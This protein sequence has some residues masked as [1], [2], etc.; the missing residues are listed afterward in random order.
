LISG[1]SSRAHRGSFVIVRRWWKWSSKCPGSLMP[2]LAWRDEVCLPR[3]G[4]HS[5]FDSKLPQDL[6]GRKVNFP[7]SPNPFATRIHV[8]LFES[9]GIS[10][11]KC[12]VELQRATSSFQLACC[13]C[14]S[15]EVTQEN[16][17]AC[18]LECSAE[19]RWEGLLLSSPHAIQNEASRYP[20][21]LAHTI[22]FQISGI[23]KAIT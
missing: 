5:A 7:F 16:L 20:S 11:R 8:C 18:S 15:Y 4:F 13:L 2:Q 17:I 22:P 9:M 6:V 21:S 1:R 12:S 19:Y 3:G 23:F 10:F 14:M